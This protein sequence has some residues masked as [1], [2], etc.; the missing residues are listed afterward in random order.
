MN[1]LT[2]Y[3][4]TEAILNSLIVGAICYVVLQLLLVV[5]KKIPAVYKYH[6]SN[7]ALLIPLF[8]FVK[9]LPQLFASR[10]PAPV[11]DIVPVA[12]ET[13]A[14]L[15]IPAQ[16]EPLEQPEVS[17]NLWEAINNTI[18]AYSNEILVCYLIGLLLFT[19]RLSLQYI[20]SR[21]LKATA[22]LPANKHWQQLLERTKQ[23]LN[24]TG[25]IVL[26]FT[27]KNI[28]PC[29]IGH[30]KAMILI[31][32]SLVNN[33]STE[34]AEAILLHELA[35]YKQYDH[36]I[37]LI[38][39]CINC[40]LFFNPFTWLISKE[41]HKHRELSCDDIATKQNRNIELAE[42][43]LMIANIKT[44][45]NKVALNLKK[46]PLYNRVQTLL[47][48]NNDQKT[49]PKFLS[50]GIL[51]IVL[52]TALVF[53]SNT[54]LFSQK[55]EDNLRTE[56]QAISQQMYEEGNTNYI[57]VDAVLDSLI[58][59]PNKMELVHLGEQQFF[60]YDGY[61]RIPMEDTTVYRYVTKLE[62]LII[63]E[64]AGQKTTFSARYEKP[65]TLNDILD[66]TSHFRSLKE[67]DE[68]KV[69]RG[70]HIALWKRL[71]Q[72]M[73]DDG[74]VDLKRKDQSVIQYNPTGI[75]VYNQPLNEEQQKKYTKLFQQYIH[76]NLEED[77]TSGQ[78]TYLDLQRLFPEIVKDEN[79]IATDKII[80]EDELRALSAKMF[81]SAVQN[82]VILDAI[83]DG[84]LK[85]GEDFTVRYKRG[86][87]SIQG[88]LL[89][90]EKR[91][92]YEQKL[93]AFKERWGAQYNIW[94]EI[95]STVD[96]IAIKNGIDPLLKSTLQRPISVKEEPKSKYQQAFD[97]IKDEVYKDKLVDK[98]SILKVKFYKNTV[99]VNGQSLTGNVKKK[100]L[101]I[102]N[103]QY[104]PLD[105]VTAENPYIVTHYP[106]G[107]SF[108]TK[109]KGMDVKVTLPKK[110]KSKKEID[111]NSKALLITS[112]AIKDKLANPKKTMLISYTGE[113]VNINY[114]PLDGAMKAKYMRLFQ[115]QFGDLEGKDL[116]V[117][118][119]FS[120][121]E[122]S[123]VPYV[124]VEFG[125]G[126]V[127]EIIQD[128]FAQGNSNFII[129]KAM[130]DGFIEAG[131]SYHFSYKGDIIKVSGIRLPRKKELEYSQLMYK[132]Y[133]T[134]HI[135]IGT[136][137]SMH[138]SVTLAQ[139]IDPNSPFRQYRERAPEYYLKNDYS[140]P[141]YY[142]DRVIGM[143]VKDGILDTTK[144]YNLKYNHRGVILNGKKLSDQEAAPY[145]PILREGFGHKPRLLRSDGLSISGGE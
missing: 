120:K 115:Q 88:K 101:G 55:K 104:G 54:S 22:T 3:L 134:H 68:Q 26:A 117:D 70:M 14:T 12:S 79:K 35:H 114:V 13:V 144:K 15:P 99:I 39:Q 81:D 128:M 9:A 85:D 100:Y 103:D 47:K 63:K 73:V 67:K 7:I 94:G 34:Q 96:L 118:V 28:S 10:T 98:D 143:M 24:I 23:Q 97:K 140:K 133:Q 142:Y 126:A 113:D 4:L 123:D 42:T 8:S 78:V 38:T 1:Q 33:L 60:L 93:K 18:Q 84:Y 20:E 121:Q 62:N 37:N 138:G 59:L 125:G 105:T 66:S 2:A 129:V 122:D 53:F 124:S 40:I 48:M 51:T 141:V 31:P 49:S 108:T 56:L 58:T 139:V 19:I 116:P 46:S 145:E 102:I 131:E 109:W 92:E 17:A 74:L 91:Q 61:S 36:Y 90:P 119:L 41:A 132:F 80:T 137:G 72:D 44:A 135:G 76:I 110:E 45:E 32:V 69:Q 89:P 106:P 21:K 130:D 111:V 75:S 87:F 83:A 86:F 6:L 136:S 107:T 27:E 82:F 43:L 16:V 11:N 57:F 52:S 30:A 95:S 29:I 50:L 127:Q 5:L 65:I 71:V 77:Q 64:N 112:V 25:N